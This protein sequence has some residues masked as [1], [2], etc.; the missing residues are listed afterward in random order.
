MD[1]LSTPK[2]AGDKDGVQE[3]H[4][5]RGLR[6]TQALTLPFQVLFIDTL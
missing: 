2:V 3:R 1:S 6:F 5:E 4:C